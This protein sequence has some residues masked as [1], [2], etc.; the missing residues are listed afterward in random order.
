ME[1][2]FNLADGYIANLSPVADLY[3]NIWSS[4]STCLLHAPRHVDKSS[5]AVD[6][7]LSITAKGIS[8]FYLT[9]NRLSAD[10]LNK[11]R[12]NGHL[13]VHQSEFC[14]PD[15]PTDFADI[16]L[17]DLED[18][19]AATGVKVFVIDS[20]SR[21]AALSFG[22]NASPSYLMKRIVALQV[23]HKISI[24]VL[25]HDTT[26]A[27]L[28]KL[29]D[30]VDSELTIPEPEDDSSEEKTAVNGKKPVAAHKKAAPAKSSKKED[31]AWNRH[32]DHVWRI[33]NEPSPFWD[34][35]GLY[36]Y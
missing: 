16:V 15:D 6:I 33:N 30:L 12:G 35:K 13:Y 11:M 10:L 19:I 1:N 36:D 2:R 34:G 32:G 4:E 28:R 9:A 22:R 26:K 29:T 8:V 14:T 7:A 25:A 17:K 20:L 23:R 27:A 21:I 31:E 18:A 3:N 5:L 24:L